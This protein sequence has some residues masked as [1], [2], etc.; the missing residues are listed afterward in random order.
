MSIG[1]YTA[2][3]IS[4]SIEVPNMLTYIVALVC[5]GLMAALVG[6]IVGLPAL[7]LKGDYL[8]IVTLGFAQD[9]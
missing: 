1:A 4:K 2:A 3:L 5:G 9:L 8:A 6:L 7:R